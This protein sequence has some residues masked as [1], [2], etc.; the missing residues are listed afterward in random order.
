[1]QNGNIFVYFGMFAYKCRAHYCFRERHSTTDTSNEEHD[2]TC[3]KSKHCLSSISHF[4]HSPMIKF[5]YKFVSIYVDV[6]AISD[7]H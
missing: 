7:A 1:M 5:V 3:A 4:L 2:N 6:E